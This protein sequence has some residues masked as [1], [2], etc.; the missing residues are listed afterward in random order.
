[1]LDPDHHVAANKA[2]AARRRLPPEWT[3]LVGRPVYRTLVD[4]VKRGIVPA[5]RPGSRGG[6]ILAAKFRLDCFDNPYVRSDY[7][8]AP[9][10]SAD[11]ANALEG[12]SKDDGA[13]KNENNLLRSSQKLKPSP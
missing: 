9:T 12:R 10:N 2:D 11:T 13:L 7:A 6:T 1:M 3:I 5:E 4:Q 8:I